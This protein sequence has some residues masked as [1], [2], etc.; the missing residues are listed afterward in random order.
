MQFAIN[1][2]KEAAML[3]VRPRCNIWMKILTSNFA[4]ECRPGVND[5][6]ER[7]NVL[8]SL[9]NASASTTGVC[10]PVCCAQQ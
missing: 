5:S 7:L 10:I 6:R 2:A 9:S 4:P 8:R 1:I 3:C